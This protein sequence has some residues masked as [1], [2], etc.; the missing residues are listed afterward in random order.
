[1]TMGILI[2]I[3]LIGIGCIVLDT[4]LSPKSGWLF[5]LGLICTMAGAPAFLITSV[6][7]DISNKLIET[8]VEVVFT[9]RVAII[10]NG[11][12]IKTYTDFETVNELKDTSLTFYREETTNFWGYVDECES[13]QWKKPTE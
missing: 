1:M 9:S 6:E 13:I 7:L 5:G 11:D 4:R 2:A 12:M 8:E 3:I 10:D